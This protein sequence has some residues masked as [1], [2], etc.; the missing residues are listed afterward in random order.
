LHYLSA[1]KHFDPVGKKTSPAGKH[2]DP[3][4]KKTSPAGKQFDLAG[5]KEG[6]KSF[7]RAMRGSGL[8]FCDS[9]GF[10]GFAGGL[11]E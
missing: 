2:F 3:A 1:G 8:R 7:V 10:H 9:P 5:E 4:G 6:V 11:G